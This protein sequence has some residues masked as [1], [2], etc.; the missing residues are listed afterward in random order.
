MASAR[1][2]ILVMYGRFLRRGSGWVSVGQL[3]ELLDPLGCD[4]PS[5]RTAV[6]RM[7]R[8]GMIE[9]VDQGGVAGY[10]LTSDGE[11]FFSDG[12]RRV[13][14]RLESDGRWILASFSVPESKRRVRYQIRSRLI[15]LGFGQE[16][17]GLLIA[18]AGLG[19]EAERALR[20]DGLDG[21]VSLWIAEF[22]SLGSIA[23]VVAR[24]WDTAAIRARYEHFIESAAIAVAHPSTA[25]RDGFVQ[26]VQLWNE[27]RELAYL[28]PGLPV[29]ALA[30][31]W[32]Q[33]E[34]AR[35]LEQVEVEFGPLAERHV[36]TVTGAKANAR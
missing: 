26:Y 14:E 12:D 25:E 9:P 22:G 11:A 21:W 33:P 15:D 20:R 34:A 29:E 8:S 17:S 27:W 7:K 13:V 3:I 30:S 32:P 19:G 31:D 10:R 6:S 23:D 24:S 2:W 36:A 1:D 18:P 35:L 28:D 4:A 16:S 5:T